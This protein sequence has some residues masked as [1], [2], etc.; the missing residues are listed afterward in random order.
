MATGFIQRL[1]SLAFWGTV[2]VFF[3]FFVSS[4]NFVF[5]AVIL[6]ILLGVIAVMLGPQFIA[7]GWLIGSPTIFGFPN[8]LLRA[9]PFVT[10]ERLLLFILVVLV[11]LQY[12]YKYN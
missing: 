8:E 10:M 4:G 9:L 12:K 3:S 1:T 6:A 2:C 7:A 11:F 5:S